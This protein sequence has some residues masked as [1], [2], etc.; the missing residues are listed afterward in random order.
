MRSI[1]LANEKKRDAQVAFEPPPQ[2]EGISNKLP[3][4]ADPRGIKMLKGTPATDLEALQGAHGDQLGEALVQGDP[5]V[6]LEQ[7]GMLLEQTRRVFVGEGNK[8]VYHV[9]N[10][11]VV[12]APDG[13]EKE[14]RPAKRN[15]ANISVDEIPL[16]WTG[17]MMP[18]EKAVKMFVFSRKYQI[19]HVNG[20][21]FDFL[22][23]MAK[24]LDETNSLMFVGGGAKG[25]EPLVM[26]EGGK[27]YRAFMEGRIK[28]ETYCLI[29][30]L[31]DME[32]KE[33]MK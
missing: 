5:E 13:A 7:T 22:Y 28:G 15:T 6:D 8:I 14:R 4:G 30:H 19:R 25:N 11:E 17:K 20:L 1:N 29:L 31:T 12:R 24:K 33:I 32:M 23:D 2:K 26:S 9:R 10:E 16:S 21:T 18:K 3:S 27:S